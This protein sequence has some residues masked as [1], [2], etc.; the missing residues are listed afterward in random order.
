MTD[1][2]GG[3]TKY[4]S[5]TAEIRLFFDC[6]IHIY[7]GSDNNASACVRNL[8]LTYAECSPNNDQVQL[9]QRQ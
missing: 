8:P 5:V 7:V 1:L 9:K 4:E 6:H 3:N 2:N